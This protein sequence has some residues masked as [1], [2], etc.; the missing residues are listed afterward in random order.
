[1]PW[2]N[3]DANFEI[4]APCQ[5]STVSDAEAREEGVR[6]AALRGRFP[7]NKQR[8]SLYEPNRR[9]ISNDG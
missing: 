5:I 1:M 9:W 4:K 3:F 6:A 8:N 7:P 2:A